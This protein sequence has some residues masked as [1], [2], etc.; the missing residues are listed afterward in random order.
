VS[1][2]PFDLYRRLRWP[3]LTVAL[4]VAFASQGFADDKSDKSDKGEKTSKER[5]KPVAKVERAAAKSPPAVTP[6]SPERETAALQFAHENHPELAALLEGLKRNAP[7]E[8]QAALVDLDRAIERLGKFKEKSPERYEFELSDWKITSRIRLLAARLSMSSDPTVETELR[9]A[10]RERLEMRL[11]AQRIERDRL[12]NRA[13]KI[14]QQ[15][16]ETASRADA[17]VEKQF[18]E[19]K[20]TLPAASSTKSK[21][22]KPT[23]PKKPAEL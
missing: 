7:K 17:T 19:L 2:F 4:V 23:E 21:P 16:E 1:D 9:A 20:K 6:I 10:L 3:L 5:P 18:Q 8:Y 22:K 13:S 15:I 11:A 12:Q 14:D